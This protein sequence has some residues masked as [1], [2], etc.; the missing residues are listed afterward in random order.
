[1][2]GAN[3][4]APFYYLVTNMHVALCADRCL[5]INMT[6]GE[7]EIVEVP[8][9]AWVG[10]FNGEDIAVCAFE[11]KAHWAVDAIAWDDLAVSRS[12]MTELNAG[13]GD[14]VFMLGRFISHQGVQLS[15][16]LARFGNISMMPGEP[17]LDGRNFKV[18]AF[19]VEMRSLAGF[20]GSPVFVYMGP[21]TYRGN[22][23]MMPFYS[24]TI[25]L[26]GIDTGHK[27]T[28]ARVRD[29]RTGDDRE[30]E[31]ALNTGVSIVVPVWKIKEVL[32]CEQLAAE[33]GFSVPERT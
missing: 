13:V 25:G 6:S 12:R 24:E 9:S 1:M 8:G 29:R 14:D 20:S 11:P 5:R 18:E 33:R 27:T 3:R 10:H 23:T 31:V 21:G 17:V 30:L 28:F 15:Q 7:T 2:K 22:G 4:S 26:L 16:P 32:D 19:L